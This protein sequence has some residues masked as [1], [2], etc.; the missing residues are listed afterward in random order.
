MKKMILA[1]MAAAMFF[2]APSMASAEEAVDMSKLSCKE[3]LSA[4]QSK[5][6]MMLMWIDGYMSGKSDNTMMDNA[7]ME[8]LGTHMGKYCASNPQKTIMDAIENG[9]V[10]PQLVARLNDL[11][12]Q[13]NT[14]P[15][16][17]STIAKETPLAFTREQ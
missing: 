16:Q 13:E 3:F 1:A 7:W 4:D 10:A 8:K 5:I 9:S 14:L 6:G 15:Y 17:L 2:T 12:Q 11:T